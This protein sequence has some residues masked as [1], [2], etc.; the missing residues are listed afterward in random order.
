MPILHILVG[1]RTGVVEINEDV[2]LCYVTKDSADEVF[3]RYFENVSLASGNCAPALNICVCHLLVLK[4]RC[5]T[6]TETLHLRTWTRWGISALQ[7]PKFAHP[8]KNPAGAHVSNRVWCEKQ[9]WRFCDF[10]EIKVGLSL[11]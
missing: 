9:K 10:F 3:I 6:L 4:K 8:W 5:Q 1:L 11:V 2:M 7:T